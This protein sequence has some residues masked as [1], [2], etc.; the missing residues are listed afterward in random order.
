MK[1]FVNIL[2]GIIFL[3]INAQIIQNESIKPLADL[4]LYR[5]HHNTY[6]IQDGDYFKDLNGILTPYIGVWSGNYDDKYL[7]I[8]VT[9]MKEEIAGYFTDILLI[10][11]KIET[12]GGEELINTIG[13]FDDYKDHIRG[14]GF[15]TEFTLY[16]AW[17]EGELSNCNQQGWATLDLLNSQTMHF[18]ISQVTEIIDDS[19]PTGNIHILPTVEANALVLTKQ[20]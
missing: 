9:V 7:E 11:Y 12:L 3:N 5:T 10:K 1:H 19:C 14:Y 6:V 16:E 8:Q 4:D 20:N 13:H 17:Y 18:W 2:L 15:K